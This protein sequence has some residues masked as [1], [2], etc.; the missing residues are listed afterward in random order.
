MPLWDILEKF[1][2]HFANALLKV[3]E[4]KLSSKFDFENFLDFFNWLLHP[5][6]ASRLAVAQTTTFLE[7]NLENFRNQILTS[8][9]FL[10]L[11][12]VF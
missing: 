12:K 2:D 3:R 4:S 5:I 9:C 10:E 7:K 1:R 6:L 8:I 11:L